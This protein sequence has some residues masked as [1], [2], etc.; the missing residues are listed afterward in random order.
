MP[1][2]IATGITTIVIILLLY[3]ESRNELPGVSRAVWV[4]I[5]WMALAGSRTVSQWLN[6]ANLSVS[7]EA[8]LEG[9]P[10]DRAVFFI[11]ILVGIIILSRRQ[12]KMRFSLRENIWIIAYFLFGLISIIWSDFPAISFKRL[13]K[14]IG[15]LIMALIILSEEN[16]KEAIGAVIRRIAILLLPLSVLLIKYYPELGRSYHMGEPM[17]R[18]AAL[19]KNSLGQLCLIS[20]IYLAWSLL[21]GKKEEIFKRI[22]RFPLFFLAILPTCL[23]LLF[24]SRSATSLMGMLIAIFVL[25]NA[26]V[27]AVDQKPRRLAGIGIAIA[28]SIVVIEFVFSID[29]NRT[30]IEGLLGRNMDLT[31]RSLIWQDLLNM[32]GNPIFGRGYESFWLGDR[33]QAMVGTYGILQA[34]NGYLETYLNLGWI[35]LFLMVILM[36]SGVIKAVKDMRNDFSFS[37]LKFLLLVVIISYSWTEAILYGVNNLWLLFLF[38]IGSVSSFKKVDQKEMTPEKNSGREEYYLPN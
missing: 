10:L 34:H 28:L 36:V 22:A 16:P 7:Y 21:E 30:I 26:R 38:S 18:G 4:V 6:P 20:G 17:M 11:L 1:P 9:N 15:T 35:G 32:A 13:F 3:Y 12:L 27:W 2:Q 37:L 33:L 19:H 24:Q 14:T 5:I 23:W 31:G 29:L 8:V 25:L